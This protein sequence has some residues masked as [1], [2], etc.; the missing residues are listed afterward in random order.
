[1]SLHE[2][3]KEDG[4]RLAH[5]HVDRL[6]SENLQDGEHAL[7][8]HLGERELLLSCAIGDEARES[9]AGGVSGAR[10]L[11]ACEKF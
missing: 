8:L 2:V 1:M 7:R 6:L 9:S 3:L 5:G 10:K 11:M 4:R